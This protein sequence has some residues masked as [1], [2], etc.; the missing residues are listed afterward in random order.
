MLDSG[1][2]ANVWS[3]LTA[4]ATKP[5]RHRRSPTRPAPARHPEPDASWSAWQNRRHRRRDRQ[6]ERPL[7]PVP[8]DADD[9]QR[10][11]TPTLQ[12]VA[13]GLRAGTDRAPVPGTV[14]LAP[15][16]PTTE[17]DADGDAVRLQRPRRRPADLPLPLATATAPDPRRDRDTLNLASAGNGD[18]GDKLRVEVYAT[19][20][21]GAASDAVEAKVTVADTAPTAGTVTITPTP[22]STNDVLTAVPAG[23]ADIDG[24]TL[25]YR[26]QWLRN[27]TPIAG[28]TNR[29]LDLAVAGNGDFG[30]SIAVDVRADDGFGGLSPPVRATKTI[31]GTNSTPVEGDVSLA[32]ASP[33]TDQT[34]TATPSGF[35]EPDGQAMTY[36]LPLAAQ[37]HGD[38]RPD[39]R[40]AQPRDRRQRRPRG[41]DPRRGRRVATRAARRATSSARPS[42]S[43]T[44]R[45]RPGTVTVK[46][47]APVDRRLVSATVTGFADADGD[48]LTYSYQWFRNGT[49]IAGRHRPHARPLAARQRRPR[50]T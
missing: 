49:A 22:P 3:T 1:P 19:D 29:K 10:G 28:A 44:R 8:R 26:Y 7:H 38:R 46:P 20:G 43:P 15:A 36:T 30:D 39:R 35:R 41:H 21:R 5:D 17:P 45:R 9:D 33:R 48:A 11:V 24:D 13:V 25:T 47:A 34:V 42:R 40:D 23:F 27:G 14:A 31:T 4:T 50:T 2:G 6:P 12:R 18:R 16:A 37:R 32:P